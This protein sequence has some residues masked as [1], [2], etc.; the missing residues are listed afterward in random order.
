M[1]NQLFL[2]VLVV[3]A[4]FLLISNARFADRFYDYDDT[5]PQVTASCDDLNGVV[6]EGEGESPCEVLK[7]MDYSGYTY[8]TQEAEDH[9][10]C[11]SICAQQS[12]KCKS[13]SFDDDKKVCELKNRRPEPTECNHSTSGY[14]KVV[15][16]E[17]A[18]KS[19][20]QEK[21]V[22]GT[23]TSASTSTS[24]GPKRLGC[25]R[26]DGIRHLKG[27][28]APHWE[29]MADLT[30]EKCFN[31][32]FG[33]NFRYAGLQDGN[34][35]F[36]DNQPSRGFGEKVA[37]GE[38][39][40]PC[41][42]DPSKTCGS[43]YR[44]DI[45]D[46]QQDKNKVEKSGLQGPKRLGCYRDDGIR[47]LKGLPA[48]H[49]AFMDDMVPETCFKICRDGN[50]RYAALQDGQTCFCDNQ[51]VRGFG[52][53]VADG[54]CGKPCKGDPKKTCGSGYRNEIYDLRGGRN[55]ADR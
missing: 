15:A 10:R 52:E 51:P 29:Y 17:E 22:P 20:Q 44:N 19:E 30:P 41:K 8:A 43:G 37:D 55:P 3:I 38:C 5:C 4:V 42:G 16:E 53:K 46:L 23:S 28:P 50:F 47:H 33:K 39:G 45:F 7:N 1:D 24:T 25:F 21:P 18:V 34:S 2:I 49:W 13:W 35:C 11:C 6:E 12:D 26:D 32:C 48:P 31:F 9:Q 14:P 54:E 27:L 40:K 36:C